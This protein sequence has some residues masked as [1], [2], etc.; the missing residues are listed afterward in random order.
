MD[1]IPIAIKLRQ[2]FDYYKNKHSLDYSLE[3]EDWIGCNFSYNEKR[4]NIDFIGIGRYSI[5]TK[6]ILIRH[7]FIPSIEELS[8]LILLHEIKHSID[9]QADRA[10]YMQQ[11][12]EQY[13]QQLYEPRKGQKKYYSYP[14]ERRA[15]EFAN[16]EFKKWR[17]SR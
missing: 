13:I 10:D 11:Q 6:K 3:F 2:I 15:D 4:I 8:I 9:Y 17:A 14:L 1:R 16:K 7:K 12:Y 5:N